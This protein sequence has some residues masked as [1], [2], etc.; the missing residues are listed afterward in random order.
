[1]KIKN[2]KL[3]KIKIYIYI[4]IVFIHFSA[5]RRPLSASAI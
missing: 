2:N 5:I 4:Y 3:K 1:M